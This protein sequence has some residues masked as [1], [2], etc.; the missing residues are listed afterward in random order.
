MF[1]QYGTH[2]KQSIPTI[3]LEGEVYPPSDTARMMSNILFYLRLLLIG[4]ILGGPD[5]MTTIGINQTP[6]WL[7]WM[8][9]NKVVFCNESNMSVY[10]HVCMFACHENVKNCVHAPIV[11]TI[12]EP[13]VFML[14]ICL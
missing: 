1:E 12:L 11:L 8:F 6:H 4:V 9:D 10:V 2:L 13:V 14:C 3:L 5:L 7:Q